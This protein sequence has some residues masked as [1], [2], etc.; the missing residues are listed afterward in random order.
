VTSGG[1]QTPL[2]TDKLETAN[3]SAILPYAL[4]G[5]VELGI[6]HHRVDL[7]LYKISFSANCSARGV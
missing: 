4:T 7:C 5:G 2:M 1:H 6:D 3:G